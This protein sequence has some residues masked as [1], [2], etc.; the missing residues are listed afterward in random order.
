MK[1]S[2]EVKMTQ[3]AL[4]EFLMFHTY[5]G[6]KGILYLIVGVGCWLGAIAS[7]AMGKVSLGLGLVLVFA[8]CLFIIPMILKFSAGSQIK[9]SKIYSMPIH[10]TLEKDGL[11]VERDG[12]NKVTPWKDMYRV[13]MTPNLVAIYQTP[14]AAFIFPNDDIGPQM[15][16]LKKTLHS[17][18]S[19][20]RIEDNSG[21]ILPFLFSRKKK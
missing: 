16:P 12:K 21:R 14:Y 17:L 1:P 2:F 15:D 6:I 9:K 11:R 7:F 13:M 20:D 18:F 4:F 3:E 5:H 19:E 10:Y 8:T